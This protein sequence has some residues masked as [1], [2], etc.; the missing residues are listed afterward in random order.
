MFICTHVRMLV[1]VC[2]LCICMCVF[3]SVVCDCLCCGIS[4]FR[5]V[6]FSIVY[7]VLCGRVCLV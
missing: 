4:I 5:T 3:W 7:S 1:F 6:K 2:S